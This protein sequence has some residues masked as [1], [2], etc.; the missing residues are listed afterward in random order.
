MSSS[1]A[2]EAIG[3][4][5]QIDIEDSLSSERESFVMA[6]VRERIDAYDKTYSRFRSDSLVTKMSQESGVYTLPPDAH[7]L[8]SLYRTFYDL[9]EGQVTPLIGDVLVELGYDAQ[10]SLVAQNEV[11]MPPAWD[12][13]FSYIAP[14]LTMK[15][16]SVIDIGAGGKGHLI[17]IVGDLLEGEGI[18][19]Y[20]IDAGGDMR[21]RSVN[22]TSLRVGLENPFDVNEVIGVIELRNK[23]ICGSAGNRRTWGD[24]HHIVNPHTLTSPREIAALWVV[25]D[26]TF[27]ADMLSTAFF[28]VSPEK[29][30]SHFAFEYAMLK[31]NITLFRSE[32]FTGEFFTD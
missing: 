19:S 27:L 11:R 30:S 2:F 18:T 25:A 8:F 13:V 14:T 21:Q 10:Y 15:I 20:T 22:D 17:D 29:L 24:F 28:F 7:E 4:K 12:D 32:G 16:P 6:R 31:E 9:T 26:T 3:T 1:H 5:W 23:S